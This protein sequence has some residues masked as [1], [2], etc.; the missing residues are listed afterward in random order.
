MIGGFMRV[1]ER[2]HS[3]GH[4][5]GIR[6]LAA[7]LAA[8]IVA[9]VLVALVPTVE[10]AVAADNG[11]F[12]P[13]HIISDEVFFNEYAMTL[14]GIESFI[15]SRDPDC[16]SGTAS[17][18]TDRTCLID[19]RT[20][21]VTQKSNVNCGKYTGKTES[22]ASIIYRVARLCGVNPQVI[23][24]T[25]QKE[26]SLLTGGP[27]DSLIYRK[28]MG[29]GCPDTSV[30]NSKYYGFFNQVYRAAWQFKQ[31]GHSASFTY[32]WAKTY[33]VRY[34][35]TASCSTASVYIRNRATAALYNYTPYQ[36]NA[37]ALLAG[38]STG[39]KCSSYGNRN[40]WRYFT[41]WFG[42]PSS[43]LAG[44][45]FDGTK[46]SGWEKVGGSST[47]VFKR[48]DPRAQAGSGFISVKTA[49]AGTSIAKNVP[50][51]VRKGQSYTATVWVR[52]ASVDDSYEGR[53]IL[54]TRGGSLETATQ[55]FVAGA[56][57]TPVSVYLDVANSGHT[58]L[59]LQIKS[60][61]ANQ[62][63]FVDTASVA[64]QKKPTSLTKARLL[65]PS[66]EDGSVKGWARNTGAA[67]LASTLAPTARPA[68]DGSSFL[69]VSTTTSNSSIAQKVTRS[70]VPGESF[71]LSAWVRSSSPTQTVAG[72]LAI[73]S[74]GG[75]SESVYTAF[76]ATSE[77]TR[78]QVTLSAAKIGHTGLKAALYV[79]SPT[80]V[81]EVDDVE[82]LPNLVSNASFEGGTA[83]RWFQ[84]AGGL[85]LS[86]V[87]TNAS[88][89]VDGEKYLQ[90]MKVGTAASRL[91][92]DV[93]RVARAGDTYTFGVWLRAS[94]PDTPY[95]T[96]LRITARGGN[97]A[98]QAVITDVT[99]GP[100]WQYFETSI[101][102]AELQT[103]LRVEL[104]GTSAPAALD[105]DGASLR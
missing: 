14:S 72:R 12:D 2:A 6:L 65:A 34:S 52:S 43:L 13:G 17:D 24:V 57:W 35:P 20:K 55:N 19:F 21:S 3:H 96:Q 80:N 39:D 99:V 85:S 36:P 101:T 93:P 59:R 22:A 77:W 102:L 46:V 74:V 64:P 53:L 8:V 9:A 10:R 86:V 103:I 67:T 61:T 48:N 70:W 71:T 62:S 78:V 30:C 84:S 11:S 47:I 87:Q 41:D 7:T 25:L 66:F 76:N 92:M 105:I 82:L 44:G 69:A 100:T 68:K 63:L 104:Q 56:E 1:G 33:A 31:Y 81:L 27:R 16:V 75:G 79:T 97:G 23:L 32:K 58:G 38:S 29:M 51:T 95:K 4:R 26:Q 50:R 83:T 42:N 37:A 54:R 88:R 28:A 91:A 5:S 18:G 15:E 45:G 40:F 98:P 90:F 73:A 49:A 60:T 94:S 89:A